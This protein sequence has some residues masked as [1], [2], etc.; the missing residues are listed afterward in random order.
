MVAFIR[1]ASRF[2]SPARS[3]ARAAP[4]IKRQPLISANERVSARRVFQP[5]AQGR[6]SCVLFLLYSSSES[7]PRLGLPISSVRY[8][9]QHRA[10]V[11]AVTGQRLFTFSEV[12][13][14]PPSEGS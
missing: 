12:P 7:N 1:F 2:E 11:S 4:A 9:K 10:A 13:R 6:P 5:E 8:L 3:S 14:E